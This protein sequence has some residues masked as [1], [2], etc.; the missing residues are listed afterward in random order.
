MNKLFRPKTMRRM[1]VFMALVAPIVYLFGSLFFA[2]NGAHGQQVFAETTPTEVYGDRVTDWNGF[3]SGAVYRVYI[4]TDYFMNQSSWTTSLNNSAFYG[5]S[6]LDSEGSFSSPM[7]LYTFSPAS[8]VPIVSIAIRNSSNVTLI[9]YQKSGSSLVDNS[10][11]EYVYFK[12]MSTNFWSNTDGAQLIKFFVFQKREVVPDF[13]LTPV[14]Y[15]D[16]VFKNFFAKDNFL[17]QWGENAISENP[18]GFAPF[19]YFWRYLDTNVLHLSNEQVGL[20]AYGY[21]YYAAHVLLFDVGF[22]L[23]TFFLT[24]IQKVA[25]RI[26]G[27]DH[28]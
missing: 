13:S 23:V 26:G 8:G 6:D 4:D 9:G 10:T 1:A 28:A 22:I 2:L 17:V 16:Y 24:F 27:E 3:T 11:V 18:Y 14:G 5:Y 15:S 25:D 21:M 19:G 20:M 12:P 7:Y